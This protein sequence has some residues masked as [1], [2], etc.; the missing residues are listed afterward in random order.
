MSHYVGDVCAISRPTLSGQ[1][2]GRIM[3][4]VRPSVRTSVPWLLFYVYLRILTL[5]DDYDDVSLYDLLQVGRQRII[6]RLR[7]ISAR[8]EFHFRSSGSPAAGVHGWVERR[9]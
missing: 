8:D 6:K 5:Y 1:P 9:R 4:F 7:S 3:R 2:A